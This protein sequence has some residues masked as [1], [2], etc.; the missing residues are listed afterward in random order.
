MLE[1]ISTHEAKALFSKEISPVESAGDLIA[2][3]WID[4]L[5]A[6]RSALDISDDDGARRRLELSSVI[7]ALESRRDWVA[8]SSIIKGEIE[9]VCA[10]R[11]DAV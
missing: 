9:R 7:K 1:R 8:R 5:K 4:H 10:A 11:G 2:R 6:E 3:V